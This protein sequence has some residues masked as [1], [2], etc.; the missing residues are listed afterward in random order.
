MD[1][2]SAPN[3]SENFALVC[4]KRAEQQGPVPIR[5]INSKPSRGT[6]VQTFGFSTFVQR[7]H[8][9]STSMSST[10]T[11]SVKMDSLG[12]APG[13]VLKRLPAMAAAFR[14]TGWHCEII[15]EGS[16][17][18]RKIILEQAEQQHKNDQ[19]EK[20]TK[21]PFD[22]SIFEGMFPPDKKYVTQVS[23]APPWIEAAYPELSPVSMSDFAHCEQTRDSMPAA[24]SIMYA[25]LHTRPTG[26]RDV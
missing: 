4:P 9:F 24:A 16:D 15:I 23:L 18:M 3:S 6:L 7:A 5:R 25:S 2:G 13:E 8:G 1:A 14:E 12:G 21:E 17:T 11:Y 19:K 20:G 22:A 26:F 10:L